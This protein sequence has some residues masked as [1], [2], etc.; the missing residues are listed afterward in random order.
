MAEIIFCCNCPVKEHVKKVFF[1]VFLGHVLFLSYELYHS[2]SE[3][4]H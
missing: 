1:T 3:N 2:A 4:K